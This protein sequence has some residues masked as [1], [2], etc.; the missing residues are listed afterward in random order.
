MMSGTRPMKKKVLALILCGIVFT[1]VFLSGC[2]GT[3][4]KNR[5]AVIDTTMGTIRVELYEDKTPITTENFIKL[6]N[7]GFYNSLVF[8]RVIDNFM[9]QSGG[10]YANGTYKT[11]PYGAIKLETD[12]D[13]IHDDG[14]IAMARQ[15]EDMTDPTFF[16]TA[17]SQFYICDEA[18]H[19]LDGYYAVFGNVMDN[20][21]MA[22]V[23]AIASVQTMTKTILGGYQMPDW[24]ETDVI[25]NTISIEE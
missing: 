22:V 4:K 1:G 2:S 25:I 20:E 16:D 6:A 18:Q 11:S 13:L 15:G 21:S 14:A 19:G 3:T 12:S 23:K 9:I 7:D 8:H 5:I 10:F 17:T 24:P